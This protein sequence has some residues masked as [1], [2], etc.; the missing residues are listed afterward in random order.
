M[1]TMIIISNNQSYKENFWNL[2]FK[3]FKMTKY[4]RL[5]KTSSGSGSRS[6]SSLITKQS[7]QICSLIFFSLIFMLK[8]DEPF[9]NQEI[10]ITSLFSMV[11]FWVLKVKS[12]WLIFCLLDPDPWIRKFL[13]IRIQEGSQ[14][15]EDPK[16]W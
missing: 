15:L 9:R 10:L 5:N 8:L 3:C 14:N 12:S 7:F 4:W 6:S 16:H 2:H 13:R 11:H 1:T